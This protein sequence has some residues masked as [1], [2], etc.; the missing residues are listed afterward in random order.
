[1]FLWGPFSL[2]GMPKG[3]ACTPK[4][5]YF[6]DWNLAHQLGCEALISMFTHTSDHQ[7][8]DKYQN[9]IVILSLDARAIYL[10]RVQTSIAGLQDG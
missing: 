10:A 6:V 7:H 8:P 2:P 5:D 1:M 4:A 9:F 3:K